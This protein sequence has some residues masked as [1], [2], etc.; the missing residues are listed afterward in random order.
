MAGNRKLNFLTDDDWKVLERVCAD[1]RI[2]PEIVEQMIAEESA[3]Y[4]MGRRHRINGILEDLLSQALEQ[5]GALE[6][7]R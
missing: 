1:V 3:V 7:S 5:Q 4:G 2:P 6:V